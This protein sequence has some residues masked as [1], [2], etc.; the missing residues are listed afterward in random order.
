MNAGG[1][2]EAAGMG[3]AITT[4]MSAGSVVVF[5]LVFALTGGNP[6]ECED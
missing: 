3:T 5:F 6:V 2:P 4:G 1:G